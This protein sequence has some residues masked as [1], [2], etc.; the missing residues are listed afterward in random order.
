LRW[1]IA[2][3]DE[4]NCLTIAGSL[5]F[6]SLLALV[7][8]MT[9]V[10]LGLAFLPAYAALATQAEDFI[11]ENF[12]PSSSLLVQEKLTEFAGRAEGLTE[13]GLLGLALTTLML[14]LTIE[15]HFNAIWQV[16]KPKWTLARVLLLIVLLTIG[17]ALVLTGISVST[18]L[19]SLPL[20][21]T[22]DIIGIAPLALNHL[23][24]LCLFVVFSCLFAFVPNAVV[25]AREALLGGVL[26]TLA[27]KMAFALFAWF[28]QYF[29]YNV[30][31]GALAVLP[32]F[33]LW[34]FLVW[35]IVLLGAIFVCSMGGVAAQQDS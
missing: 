22:V 16:D 26:T 28:S 7:P 21:A 25:G 14:L 17:P 33:L 30:I 31:Y 32:V 8:A 23:P 9:V 20:L 10:Y 3:F 35:V 34:L 5:T 24:T 6:T 13:L 19:L 29:V 2:R 4:Q 27:F 11:F 18:Y 1:I 15:R 12:I